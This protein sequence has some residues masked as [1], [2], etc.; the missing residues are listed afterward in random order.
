MSMELKPV[1][2]DVLSDSQEDLGWGWGAD[3]L[4]KPYGQK[5]WNTP[6]QEFK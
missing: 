6:Y 3:M 4:M 5:R 2:V 1:T